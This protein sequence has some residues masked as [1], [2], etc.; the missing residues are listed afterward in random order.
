[1]RIAAAV[2][3]LAASSGC[4][5]V[6]LVTPEDAVVYQPAGPWRGEVETPALAKSDEF[7]DTP[8]GVRL[9]SWYCPAAEPTAV[10][11]FAHGNA[12]ALPARVQRLRWMVHQ[13]GVSVLAFDYRGYGL[14]EGRPSEAGLI[15]DARAARA[16]L[17]ALAGVAESEIVLYGRSLGGGV[18]TQLAADDGARGLILESTFT[19]LPDVA[20]SKPLLRPVSYVMQNRYASID[21]IGDYRGPLFQAH[22][23]T[24]RVVP[25]RLGERL[26]A[27][28]N[29]PKEFHTISGAGHNWAPPLDYTESL[30]RFLATL[31]PSSRRGVTAAADLGGGYALG[32]AQPGRTPERSS[33]WPSVSSKPGSTA[34]A[35]SLPAGPISTGSASTESAPPR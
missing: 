34:G 6:R 11:L 20:R 22:G 3:L 10:V 8:D 19:S 18:V 1:M 14:S 27:A 12:G 7:I 24:D 5:G 13:L 16:K 26:H 28:A 32:A 29:Q 4:A 23:D 30:I 9:H 15:A 17:A 31:P 25:L 35:V 21:R 2:L 33:S